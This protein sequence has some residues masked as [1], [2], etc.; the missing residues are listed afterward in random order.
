MIAGTAKRPCKRI[1]L[2]ATQQYRCVMLHI[3]QLIML[4]GAPH[5]TLPAGVH[6]TSLG[7]IEARFA[8]DRWR[9]HLFSGFRA[10]YDELV[11]AG[12]RCI[13]L[14]G[15]FVSDKAFPGDFDGCWDPTGVSAAKLNPILLDF[16]NKRAAQ[17]QK[18]FGEMFISSTG[19]GTGQTYLDFFQVDKNTGLPKGILGLNVLTSKTS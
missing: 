18:Y 1:D 12:C 15:S 19:A 11:S 10:A 2:S 14:D 17:K 3:P 5:A 9:A 13:Y 6:W 7:E 16:S 8:Q 4:P